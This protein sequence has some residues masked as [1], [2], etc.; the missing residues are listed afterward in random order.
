MNFQ[1]KSLPKDKNIH[2]IRRTES[3]QQLAELYSEALVYFNASVEETFGM[4][5][6]EA[7]ACGTPV[8]AYN[9]TAVP[10]TII[11]K[12]PASN[13]A[14]VIFTPMIAFAPFFFAC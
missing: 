8:I 11:P 3:Q 13:G 10:E 5:C 9:S 4:T 2:G 6:A 12:E 7:L 1:I 14:Y